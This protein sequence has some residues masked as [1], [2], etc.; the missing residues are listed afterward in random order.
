M[1]PSP[2]G[3]QT[4]QCPD[5]RI[6]TLSNILSRKW[7]QNSEKWS[8]RFSTLAGRKT[9]DEGWRNYGTRAKIGTRKD[10][11]GNGFSFLSP[12]YLYFLCPTSVSML[13]RTCVSVHISDCVQTAYELP[14]LPNNP[15]AKHF[16]TNPE[17][18]AKCWL[19]I[20]HWGAG[21]PVTGWTRD[22]GQKVLL[23]SFQ[24]GSNDSTSYFQDFPYRF[25]RGGF[26]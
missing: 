24:T 25:P 19:D 14:L 18:S 26:Y 9:L 17:R 3:I 7:S 4:S 15:A 23:S 5:I 10:F 12:V 6:V 11:L 13:W 8:S 20:Y 22:I 1:S 21:L 2:A 16:Y